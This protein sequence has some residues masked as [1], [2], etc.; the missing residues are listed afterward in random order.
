ML[1]QVT[2]QETSVYVYLLNYYYCYYFSYF[3]LLKLLHLSRERDEAWSEGGD[4][5]YDRGS[6]N[7][8]TGTFLRPLQDGC[9]LP[10]S[11]GN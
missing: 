5:R 8:G 10:L 11:T 2:K 4:F 6:C 3:F 9:H 7:V 1:Q